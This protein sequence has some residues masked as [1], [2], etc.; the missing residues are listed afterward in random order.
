MG[1]PAL[2]AQH[3]P[4][5]GGCWK[6]DDHV[7]PSHLVGFPEPPTWRHPV[8]EESVEA[9]RSQTACSAMWPLPHWLSLH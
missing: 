9:S 6:Q 4:S 1:P 5:P 8:C 3:C 2:V 7:Y